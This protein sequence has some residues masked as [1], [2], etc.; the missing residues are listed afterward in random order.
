MVC[1]RPHPLACDNIVKPRPVDIHVVRAFFLNLGCRFF[2][3]LVF[4]KGAFIITRGA[5]N[6]WYKVSVGILRSQGVWIL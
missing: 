5:T 4:D 6:E 2:L 3:S 1:W